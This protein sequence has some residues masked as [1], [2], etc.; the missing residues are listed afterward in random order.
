MATAV[1]MLSLSGCATMM[2]RVPNEWSL[3]V[4]EAY[5]ATRMDA[6]AIGACFRGETFFHHS[7]AGWIRRTAGYTI[8]PLFFIID[9]PFSLVFDTIFFPFDIAVEC[10]GAEQEP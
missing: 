7:D 6:G 8:A 4:Q 5:P 2:T 9:M 3:P 1:A 10:D